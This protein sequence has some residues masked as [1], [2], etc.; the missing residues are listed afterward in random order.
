MFRPTALPV[1]LL[2][3]FV[4]NFGTGELRAGERELNAQWRGAWVLTRLPTQSDC[5]G[6]Y[7]NNQVRGDLISSDGRVAFARGELGR[8]AKVNLNRRRIEVL[9]DF[10]EPILLEVADG[11]FVLYDEALCK[12]ELRIPRAGGD[13][14]QLVDSIAQTLERYTTPDLAREARLWNRRARE[15]Y[16][17]DYDETLAEYEVWKAQQVN[18]EVQTRR[19]ESIEQAARLIRRV[20]PDPEYLAG[21]AEG[22]SEARE[23]YFG[24]DCAGLLSKSV[25]GFVEDAPRDRRSAWGKGYEDGQA[26]YFH[27]EIAERLRGCYVTD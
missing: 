11:P 13:D 2:F 20:D 24:N 4:V 26:L 9:V 6:R 12:V 27:L 18:A 15:A 1:V 17:E 8:V 19:D 3:A 25:Y 16:P 7:T 22:V 14:A 23:E 21:F 5:G 10:A